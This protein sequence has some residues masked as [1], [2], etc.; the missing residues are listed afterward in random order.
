[1]IIGKKIINQYKSKTIEDW[2]CFCTLFFL[3]KLIAN[4]SAK[5]VLENT[6]ILIHTNIEFIS[7]WNYH[8]T[9]YVVDTDETANTIP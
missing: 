2:F 5:K 9:L 3:T 6:Y 7:C 4:N 1:M 8:G